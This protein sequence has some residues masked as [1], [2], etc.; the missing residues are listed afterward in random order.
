ML[1]LLL[2]HSKTFHTLTMVLN[3]FFVIICKVVEAIVFYSLKVD[4]FYFSK[5]RP[6]VSAGCVITFQKLMKHAFSRESLTPFSLVQSAYLSFERVTT[7][8]YLLLPWLLQM[9]WEL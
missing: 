6:F 8:M 2:Y 4:R 1:F 3:T 7:R 9:P 5:D